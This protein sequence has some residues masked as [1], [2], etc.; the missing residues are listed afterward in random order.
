MQKNLEL[1]EKEMQNFQ[2]ICGKYLDNVQDKIDS[3]KKNIT[4]LKQFF[5]EI[6][7]IF[8]NLHKTF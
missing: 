2:E 5:S 4:Y 7:D 3:R 6:A 8:D 1:S